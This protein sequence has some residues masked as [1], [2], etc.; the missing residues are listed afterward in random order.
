MYRVGTS[1]HWLGDHAVFCRPI[2]KRLCRTGKVH[3]LSNVD[4]ANVSRSHHHVHGSHS[5]LKMPDFNLRQV[6]F[7]REH[8]LN[9]EPR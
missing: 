1:K 2:L 4:S 3:A 7:R 5:L 6:L 8:L 9:N